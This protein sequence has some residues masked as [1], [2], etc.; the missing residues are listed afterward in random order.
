MKTTLRVVLGFMGLGIVC[1]SATPAA[2][3]PIIQLLPGTQPLT[4]QGDIAA[5]LVEG[6]DKFLLRE[7]DGSV[8]RR[9]RH[10]K[11]DFS[12]VEA[13]NKSIEP[14]RRHLAHIL[15]MRDPRVP[16]DAPELVGTTAQPALVGRGANYEVFADQC[17]LRRRANQL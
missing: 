9:A 3:K 1:V 2:D 14:N 10:W 17:G 12:S 4:M 8:E 7:I 13:Y 16:F 15:G 5:Q 6:V 11:R